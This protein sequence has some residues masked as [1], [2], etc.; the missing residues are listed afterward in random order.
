MGTADQ[1]KRRRLSVEPTGHAYAAAEGLAAGATS[2]SSDMDATRSRVSFEDGHPALDSTNLSS[3]PL[4]P[5]ASDRDY[6]S[7]DNENASA[8]MSMTPDE[9]SVDLRARRRASLSIRIP[10]SQLQADMAFTALQYLPMP[11]LVLSNAKTVVLAN[12]AMGRLIGIDPDYEDDEAEDE[13]MDSLKQLAPNEDQSA[14]DILHGVTLAQLGVDLLQNGAPVFVAWEEFLE[15]I[16]DDASKSQRRTTQLNAHHGRSRGKDSTPTS[17]RHRRDVSRSSSHR[18]H[19]SA[20]TR[21]EVHDAIVDVVFSTDRDPKTGLPLSSRN[22]QTEHV[23]AQMIVSVWATE[24]EQYFTLTFT[25]AAPVSS[26]SYSSSDG[27]KTSS[28]T[29]SRSATSY[30]YAPSGLSSN[31]S[32]GSHPGTKRSSLQNA[33]LSLYASPTTMSMSEFPPKGPPAKASQTS[34]PTMFSKTNRLK[35]A[36]LNSMNIPAY[37]MWKDESFGIPNKAAIKLIY[38]W[39]EDGKWETN[40]QAR[41]FLSRYKLYKGDFSGEL[42]FEEFPI[43][44]LMRMRE[45]FEGYRI[46]MYSAK[47]G[48]RL[49]FDVSGEPITDEKGEFLGGLVLFYDVTEYATTIT[50]QQR[51]KEIQFENLCNTVPQMMCK[52]MA[53]FPC[54]RDIC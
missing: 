52:P 14:T 31:S 2:S 17:S 46:G 39:I 22:D 29:V 11:I 30:S 45:R 16:V 33:Q 15:T 27:A 41:D 9:A 34:A 35:E 37:A 19:S 44:R 7:A 12:E 24:D 49:L 50:N 43:L 53:P 42:P 54:L 48:T 25:A 26:S 18:S 5:A 20:G 21:T 40:E 6:F 3:T 51:D 10:P 28:R 32:T 4:R 38:P 8:G 23:Q 1:R 47:D 13:D 36:L